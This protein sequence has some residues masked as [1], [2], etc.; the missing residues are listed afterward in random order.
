MNC[1]DIDCRNRDI[2][3][4]AGGAVLET[5]QAAIYMKLVRTIPYHNTYRRRIYYKR[6]SLKATGVALGRKATRWATS[7]AK[8]HLSI[9]KEATYS[10]LVKPAA[11]LLEAYSRLSCCCCFPF[12]E[13]QIHFTDCAA[14]RGALVRRHSNSS[15]LD[16]IRLKRPSRVTTANKLLTGLQTQTRTKSAFYT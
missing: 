5:L 15:T 16:D 6:R 9:E 12:K 1:V 14:T 8:E 7:E 13:G 3:E 4:H 11:A 2:F 10:H